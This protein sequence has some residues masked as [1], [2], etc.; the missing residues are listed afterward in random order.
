MD[1]LA[2]AIS[3]TKDM[4]VNFERRF[5][6]CV[7]IM[8]FSTFVVNVFRSSSSSNEAE[9]PTTQSSVLNSVSKI[10]VDFTDLLSDEITE[11]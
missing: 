9:P 2:K 4:T 3:H 5:G 7:R 11:R 6:A 1:R 8:G 10:R